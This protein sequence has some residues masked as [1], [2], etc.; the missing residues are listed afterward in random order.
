MSREA[1]RGV[2]DNQEQKMSL[3]AAENDEAIA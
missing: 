3:A 1:D 2:R